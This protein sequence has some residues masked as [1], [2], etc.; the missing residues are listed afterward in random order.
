MLQSMGSQRGG[1]NQ[2]TEL[3]MLYKYLLSVFVLFF[4]FLC[5]L[6]IQAS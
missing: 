5:S 3:S 6:E 1:Y 4:V 2:A